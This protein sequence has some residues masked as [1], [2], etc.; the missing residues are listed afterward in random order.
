MMWKNK[1]ENKYPIEKK[2]RKS[3]KNQRTSGDR[4]I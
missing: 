4:N 2:Q 1:K 3:D